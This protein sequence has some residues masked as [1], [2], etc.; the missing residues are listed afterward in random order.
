[1]NEVGAWAT[2][3]PQDPHGRVENPLELMVGVGGQRSV[4]VLCCWA[5]GGQA[6]ENTAHW[7]TQLKSEAGR[8]GG[9]WG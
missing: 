2:G 1:M 5:Y 8:W 4:L 7:A 6:H 3:K 9:I